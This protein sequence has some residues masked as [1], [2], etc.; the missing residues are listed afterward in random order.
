M[1]HDYK[2]FNLTFGFALDHTEIL[3]HNEQ[4]HTH[5]AHHITRLSYKYVTNTLSQTYPIL[6]S[7]TLSHKYGANTS[8]Q[9]YPIL[10]IIILSHKYVTNITKTRY[11]DRVYLNITDTHYYGQ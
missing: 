10:H 6:H 11:E 1:I 5:I 7:I 8:S 2:L 3:F 9:T 4:L